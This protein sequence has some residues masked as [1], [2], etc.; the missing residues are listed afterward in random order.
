MTTL[1]SSGHHRAAPAGRPR[2]LWVTWRQHRAAAAGIGLLLGAFAVLLGV[3]GLRMQ[4]AYA[5]LARGGC[6][7][8]GA[9]VSSRCGLLW[10]SYYHAGYPLTGNL[11]LLAIALAILPVLIGV[12]AGAPLLA[13]EYETGTVRFAWTQAAG[14]GHWL[15]AKL[16]LLG[17]ALATAAATFGALAGWWLLL[18]DRAAGSS[19]WQPQ[20]FGLTAVSFAG[21][22][23]FMLAAGV[24]AGAV[25]RRTV[26]AMAATAAA[27]AVLIW[28]TVEK[29]ASLLT[30]YG[31]LSG[32][33]SLV[34][35]TI[36]AGP[37]P[38]AA[39]PS[40]IAA[41]G[42]PGSWVLGTWFTGPHGQHV[43]TS[44][45]SL[46]PLWNLKLSASGQAAWLARHH[47]TLWVSYQSAGRFWIFQS[48]VGGAAV[49][50][51][52]LLAAAAVWLV[53]RRTA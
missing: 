39:L 47:L 31:P 21:W 52:L 11:N 25:T 29:L 32:R 4:T 42:P 44:S 12:F 10:G 53:R 9:D 23:V 34:S 8:A 16:G 6:I 28:F 3:T 26:P 38:G 33:A 30:A 46:N 45:N 5:T 17:V 27:G 50:L 43:S 51:A 14:R 37:S 15:A 36:A 18:A 49:L 24:L 2:M 35:A 1:T 7:A 40:G 22:M 48:V 41:A 20:Q 19:R 13:R